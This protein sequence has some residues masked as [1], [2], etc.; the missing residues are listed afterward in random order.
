MSIV[1]EIIGWANEQSDWISDAVRRIL[2]Q[3]TLKEE[4][5]N[6]LAAILKTKYGFKD[7]NERI[8]KTLDPN[9][10][11]V[12]ASEAP[13]VSLT[14]IR[15]PQNLN[16]IGS[17]DGITFEPNGLTI[18]YGHN[19]AGKSGY[20]RALKKA[21]R[22]RD[23]EGILPNVFA[24]NSTNAPAQARL[25]WQIG[26][27][28]EAADWIDDGRPAPADLSRIAVFDSHC[29]RVF[30]DEQA[31]VSYI[32]YGLDVLREL[33]GGLQQVQKT[34]EA[35]SQNGKFDS[36]RLIP[37]HGDTVVGKLVSSLTYLT[38]HK[39][40]KELA[41]LSAEENLEKEALVKILR[42]ED[43]AKH[44]VLLRRLSARLQNLEKELSEIEAPLS[45]AHIDK[46]KTAFE[47]LI[48]AEQASKMA[49]TALEDGGKAIVGTGSEPWEILVKSAFTFATE[50]AYPGHDF[51]GPSEEVKCVL[52]QQPLTAE[53]NER[54][55][56]FIKFLE[57]DTQKQYSEKRQVA[58]TLYKSIATTNLDGFP[59]DST[60]LDEL[61]EQVPE[62]AI[63]IRTSITGLKSRKQA[64]I[65]MAPNRMIGDLAELP[66][67]ATPMIKALYDSK[68]DQAAKL[69][70][71]L[72]VEQRKEKTAYLTELESRLELQGLLE[73]VIEAIDNMKRDH[74]Y[75]EAI[76][77]CSTTMVTKKMNEL[78]EKTVTAELQAALIQEFKHLG[79]SES[80]VGI[81]MSGQ[82][83]ARMQK[84]KLST[85]SQYSKLKPSGVL[86]EGEQRAVALASFLAEISIAKDGSGIIFDDPVSS[87]DHIRRE[88]IAARLAQEAKIR[89]VAVFTHDLAFAWSLR[90]FAKIH[91]TNHSE[92]HVYAAGNT[93]GHSRDSLPFEARKLD[94][95]VNELRT[96]GTR[97]KKV[98][99]KEQDY[100]A[101]ND[102]V[103]QG[104]RR[105]RDTW[106]LVVED[107]LFNQAVKRFRR[108]VE[109]QRLS[110]VLVEDTDVQEVSLGMSRCSQFTHEGGAEA[111]PP[112]PA[113][114]DFIADIEMLGT[115][116]D[117]LMSR[118]KDVAAR[119]K[120]QGMQT[121]P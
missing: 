39:A 45:N 103:R 85:M 62:L 26:D 6:D 90:D 95:R 15:S 56:S 100:E 99:E 52:C 83:G 106:E 42:D 3:G 70:Q 50:I 30:V 51:P 44:A 9:T 79:L 23:T 98:L 2:E 102:L 120:K 24:S 34:L 82:R 108:S 12:Q 40:V 54:L 61:A 111:P 41:T 93:K 68:I 75:S 77:A 4:D 13:A 107:L 112:L 49:A 58:A 117:R 72:T 25:E 113:P 55:I 74:A 81:E 78:Y 110:S 20:A 116:I 88:R 31:E 19:G 94:A 96:L 35:E 21:C 121:Q 73:T 109:T 33:A 10:L 53:A 119:R 32:P 89:Q 38:D 7:P 27:K 28:L 65:S 46:L 22:A 5:V 84:L 67:S 101:Y 80:L 104:Y 37:L 36:R 76:G 118:L 43:P 91:G 87:L 17:P 47:Q 92:R 105:M 11:P 14:A 64:V 8:A 63:A 114:D 115:T 97:A 16:A 66:S 57:A 18:I 60:L 59:T 69:D 71:A 1:A 29:A 86:S 48:V